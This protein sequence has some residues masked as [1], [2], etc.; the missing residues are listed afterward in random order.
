MQCQKM[1]YSEVGLSLRG[2][3]V[4]IFLS[5]SLGTSSST[6]GHFK[7]FPMNISARKKRKYFW[8]YF[9]SQIAWLGSLFLLII[10]LKSFICALR[11]MSLSSFRDATADNR[12]ALLTALCSLSS[13]LLLLFTH[14]YMNCL[15][16]AIQISIPVLIIASWAALL[17]ALF[18]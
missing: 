15:A 18:L 14:M 16:K 9:C 13:S 12:T 3:L 17:Q 5:S 11:A 10:C 8:M 7:P 6:S 4:L 2:A 1:C